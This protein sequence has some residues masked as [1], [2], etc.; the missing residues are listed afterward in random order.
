ME[1]GGSPAPRS[2]GARLEIPQW[3]GTTMRKL[4]S[5]TAGTLA[6]VAALAVAPGALAQGA[7]GA[8]PAEEIL[9]RYV[10]AIGGR[11]VVLEPESSRATGT[12]AMPSAGLTGTMTTMGSEPDRMLL[13]IELPGI[14]TMRTGYDGEVGWSIDPMTGARILESGELAGIK[15]QANELAQVRDP[16]LFTSVETIGTSEVDGEACHQVKLAWKSGRESVDC[17]SAD[18]GLLLTTTATQKSPMG[19]IEVMTR[20]SDYQEFGGIRMPTRIAQDVMGQSI[21]MTIESVE[22]DVVDDDAFDLPPEIEARV[23]AAE[24]DGR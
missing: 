20:F 12:F 21:V 9:E 15:D 13:Q 6:A 24:E 7:G 8:P 19:S 23:E 14:G 5:R 18:T 10:E 17:Y 1:T 2:P 22:F 11:D 16:S 4:T 3:K